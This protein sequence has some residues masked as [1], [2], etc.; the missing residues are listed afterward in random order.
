MKNI[1]EVSDNDMSCYRYENGRR[2]H[3]Y[4]DGAYWGPND[5]GDIYHQT[6]TH[7]L[8]YLTLE[9]KMLLAPISNPRNVLDIGTGVGLWATNFADAYPEAKVLGTDL[10]PI[11]E[12]S[13][14]PNLYFQVDDCCSEWTFLEEHGE[15]FD[16]IHMRCLYGSIGDWPQ[17]YKRCF[18]HLVPGG[19]VEQAE[20]SIVPHS[21]D[22][23]L[24]PDSIFHKWQQFWD[25]CSRVTGKSWLICDTMK[26]SIIDAGFVDVREERFKWPIGTWGSDERSQDIGRWNRE[27]WRSGT[28]GWVMA[29]STRHLGWTAEQA[30]AFVKETEKA[31]NDTRQRVYYEV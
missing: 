19:Y 12:N 25:E 15:L 23:T 11:W 21:A 28:E 22:G 4:R 1:H 14:Q 30:R 18:D 16:I 13:A 26:Q 7:H 10:S 5:E 8:F 2:Y 31:L 29:L 24:P 20:M 6:V 9:D 3:A 27:F 17:L